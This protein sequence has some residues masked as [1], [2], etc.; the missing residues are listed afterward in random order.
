MYYIT[1]NIL[2]DLPEKLAQAVALLICFRE[3]GT[4]NLGR[5]TEYHEP[6]II[7]CFNYPIV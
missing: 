3:V 5:D 7:P 4:S 2:F 6:H 1:G